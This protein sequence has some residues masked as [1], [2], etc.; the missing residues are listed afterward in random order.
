[1]V[2]IPRVKNSVYTSEKPVKQTE[3]DR[4][5]SQS[6]EAKEEIDEKK[7]SVAI[8]A[9][10]KAM[11]SVQNKIHASFSARRLSVSGCL[12]LDSQKK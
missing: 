10:A 3:P 4:L 1:M 8:T 11:I 2:N 9:N 6:A 7:S 5:Q 12:R